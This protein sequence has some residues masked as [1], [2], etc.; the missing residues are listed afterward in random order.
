M[1]DLPV[2]FLKVLNIPLSGK[3]NVRSQLS[4]VQGSP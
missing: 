1:I 2:M 4:L 3:V